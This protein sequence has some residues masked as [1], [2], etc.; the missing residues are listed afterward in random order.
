[1]KEIGESNRMG[2]TRY[3][4]KKIVDIKRIFHANMD[5]KNDRKVKVLTEEEDAKE[6]WQE[7]TE[8]YKK[9]FSQFSSVAQLYRTRHDSMYCSTPGHPVHHQ[10]PELAQTHVH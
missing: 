7:Y 4:F 10:P 6:R 8:L 2:K 5:T 3:L 9:V 1:M